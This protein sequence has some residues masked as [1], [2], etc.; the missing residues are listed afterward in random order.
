[1]A[2]IVKTVNM[3]KTCNTCD[4]MEWNFEWDICTCP[5]LMKSADIDDEKAMRWVKTGRLEDCPLEEV[6]DYE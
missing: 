4:F 5:L 2:V 3:P 1:M 6:D